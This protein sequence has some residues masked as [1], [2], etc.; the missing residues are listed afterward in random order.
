MLLAHAP[1]TVQARPP[2]PQL[3]CEVY[4]EAPDCVGGLVTCETCHTSTDP[5]GWNQ[6]GAYLSARISGA[7]TD[8][9]S[10]LRDALLASEDEDTDG[11]GV[12]NLEEIILGTNPG[13]PDSLWMPPAAPQEGNPYYKLGEY[14]PNFAYRR[15]MILY[16]GR[17]PSYEEA[18]AMRGLEGQAARDRLHEDLSMCLDGDYWRGLGLRE[19]A[20]PKVKP[21][22]AVGP[23][24][25]VQ[26]SGLFITLADYDWDYRMWRYLMSD[27]RDMRQLL[28]AQYHV[29]EDE[30]GELFERV[31]LI[32]RKSLGALAGGQ[33]LP[34]EHRAGM[35]T[36]QWFLMSNT[37][38]SELPRTTAAQAYRAFLDMD[39]SKNEGIFPVAG[40]P[41]DVDEKGVQ[42]PACAQCHSTL[43][44]LAYAFSYYKGI[45]LEPGGGTGDFDPN[46]PGQEMPNWNPDVHKTAL[47]GQEVANVVEWGR[48]AS[49]SVPFRKSMVATLWRH[50][51]GGDPGP[52]A[53]DDFKGIVDAMPE[54]GFSANRAIHRLVDTEAFGT[55]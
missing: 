25:T 1:S 33:P 42:E 45:I 14:D 35:I 20:D 8:F 40:E 17:S 46:R 36:T 26:I 43:D 55:P 37:M 18:S 22:K 23:D 47:F 30:N 49:E 21:I 16:C 41:A 51:L 50:A 38:F 39:I 28:T 13:N 9:E 29:D 3:F 5:V 10:G 31:G 6:F 11:D 44:P 53:A 7:G 15:A 32:N 2:G 27:D 19:L 24:T 52:G 34:P 4:P 54:D 48:V 12:S